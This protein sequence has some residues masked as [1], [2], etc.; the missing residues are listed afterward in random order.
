MRRIKTEIIGNNLLDRY[1][2]AQ[3]L[4]FG[5]W[6]VIPV[7]MDQRCDMND[8]IIY[9]KDAKVKVHWG[10]KDARFK[11]MYSTC[12][13]WIEEGKF[14]LMSGCVGLSAEFTMQDFLEDVEIANAPMIH[15]GDV[16]A[17][18]TYSKK[19]NTRFVRMMVVN[20]HIDP[21]CQVVATLRN[22]TD[23]EMEEISR[24]INARVNEF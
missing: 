20:D 9:N 14:Q 18:A 12:K 21:H 16:V 22:C 2:I 15:K 17:V 11:D 6:P 24:Y 13:I 4:N 10:R 19:M 7:D 23:E 8:K 1:S 3:A 5:H